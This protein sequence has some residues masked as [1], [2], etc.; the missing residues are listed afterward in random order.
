MDKVL[1]NIINNTIE[2]EF[3]S[4][5]E[6]YMEHLKK[7]VQWNEEEKDYSEKTNKI[8]GELCKVL[9]E[10]YHPLVDELEETVIA[11]GSVEAR[12]AFKEGLVLG[13]TEL[14]YLT[15]VGLEITCI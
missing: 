12:V 9:P 10:E 2:R 6:N 4:V 15:E 5:M 3:Q 7:N 11:L 1:K 8:M 13:V 14:N